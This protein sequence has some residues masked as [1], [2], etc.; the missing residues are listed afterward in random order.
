MGGLF[1][2]VSKDDCVPDLF[3]GTDYHSHLGTMRGG[4]A[5]RNGQGFTRF[6]H[7]ITNAQFRSKFEDDLPKLQ[8]TA[9]IGSISD[10]EDQ[11]L[12]IG[13]HHGA[14]AIVT[15]SKLDNQEELVQTA[16]KKRNAHFSEMSGTEINPTELVASLINEGDT[17]AEGIRHAQKSIKGSCSILLLAEDGIYAARD[18]LGR[19]PIVIAEKPGA[20]AASLETCAFPNLD[21]QIS[22]YLGPGEIV[23]ITADGF[24]QVMPPGDRLQICSF[25]WVYYGYPASD[26]ENINVEVVRN[27]CGEYL[28]KR[29]DKEVDVVAGIPDSGVGHGYGYS[30]QAG[31]AY[32][33]PFVKYTPTW[34]RSFMPQ[35]QRVRD[36]V[37][38]MK[39][40][41][42]RDLINGKRLLFCEDS[43]VRGTQLQDIVKRLFDYGALEVHMRPA[44]P[45]LIHSCKFLNFSRSRSVMDLAGRKA[46]QELQPNGPSEEDLAAY[47]NPDTEQHTAMVDCIGKR[48][49]LSSLRYQRL[50]DLVS[51]IGLPKEKLCTYCWD[52]VE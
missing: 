43:I 47:A 51:A 36:V 18:Y 12:I 19:T 17:L 22:K 44:C 38:R 26:Y 27:R 11:P 50:D 14:Y 40:V 31:V 28:A 4:L 1:G 34:P 37:A 32:R 15:V 30:M 13:S 49:G 21:Y 3:Y 5:V 24:E 41:P 46:I 7:D 16:F 48:L 42:I 52:G 33:R 2:V 20:Y 6:I 45:P 10:Y 8:G 39:L 9:G 23:K 35:D 25:L 29:D